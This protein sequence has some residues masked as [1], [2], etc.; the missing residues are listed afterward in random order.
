MKLV[1]IQ[2]KAAYESLIKNGYLITNEN[3]VNEA[4]YGVPY[5]FII[6][7]M[8][9]IDNVYKAKYPIWAWV[10]YGEFTSPPKN[11][12]LGFFPKDDNEIVRITFEKDKTQV[13]INDYVKYHFLLTNEYLPKTYNDYLT[14]EKYINSKG[15]GKNDLLAVVRRDKFDKVRDDNSFLEVNNKIQD[16]YA[17]IF[18]LETNY[19]QAT[20]WDIKLSDVVKVEFIN[21]EQCSKRKSS[22]DFRKEYIAYLKHKN[23]N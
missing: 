21:K 11:R 6:N 2:T 5:R 20:V 15:V 8:K 14:F 3:F 1:T 12:L 19:L 10:K 9:N 16:S 17:D 7:H 4:K 13:L 18:N 22:R 23:K